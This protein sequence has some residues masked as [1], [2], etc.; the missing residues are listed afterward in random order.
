MPEEP[1]ASLSSAGTGTQSPSP[2]LRRLVKRI[3]AIVLASLVLWFI[4]KTWTV[5]RAPVIPQVS[6]LVVN[7][8]SQLNPIRV[9]E[10][11]T[12]T[13]TAEIVEAVRRHTEPISIGGARHSMGGQ[14]ATDSALFVDMRQFNRIVSF[15]PVEKIINVH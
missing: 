10:V 3:I 6:P 7:D 11:I 12:P 8:V 13:T 9:S 1:D 15:A 4:V 2:N 14:T 5:V